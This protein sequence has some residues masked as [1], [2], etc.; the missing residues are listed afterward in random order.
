[1][2]KTILIVE[3]FDDIRDLKRILIEVRGYRVIEATDGREAVERAREFRP[4]P[5]ID[6]R[7]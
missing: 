1:V 7:S 3:D 6:E 5:Y 2:A 4:P